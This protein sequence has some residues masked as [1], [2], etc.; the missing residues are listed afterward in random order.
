MSREV[1]VRFCES[2][3]VR[4]RPATHLVVMVSG[5]REHAEALRE[6]MADVLAPMGLRLSSE[7]TRVVHVDE[8]FDFLSF[9]IRRFRKRGTNKYY[10]YTVPSKK[11]I[12]AIK[13][14][15]REKTHRSTRVLELD[16]LL[17]ILNGALRGWANYF[18]YG[19]SKVVFK[20]V[21]DFTWNRVMRWI[22]VKYKGRNRLTMKQMRRRFCD[23]G[24]RFAHNGVVFTGAASVTVTRYRYRG[25]RIPN[26][27]Q[28][29]PATAQAC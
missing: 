13:G 4:L 17:R 20:A 12:E 6:E 10:V 15:V 3:A 22:R 16:R 26:P 28:P 1:Q 2:R 18:R 9:T 21:D 25:S 11:A 29:K 14:K 19:V 5:T 27:W 23:R 24:W 7:K 8:G